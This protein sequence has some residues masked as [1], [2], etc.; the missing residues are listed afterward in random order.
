MFICKIGKIVESRVSWMPPLFPL[1][2]QVLQPHH[3]GF[4]VIP[5]K[6]T[7]LLIWHFPCTCYRHISL[8]L[9]C[10]NS[11]FHNTHCLCLCQSTLQTPECHIQASLG[12]YISHPLCS[13]SSHLPCHSLSRSQLEH[14]RMSTC[15]MSC[16]H[17]SNQFE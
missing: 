7:L 13:S 10:C 14:S 15:R 3:L 5:Y 16:S 2:R 6:S 4:S 17:E 12:I 9:E 8:I 1:P 11:H